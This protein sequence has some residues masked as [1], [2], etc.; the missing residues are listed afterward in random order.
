VL[1]GYEVL[2]A[3]DGIEALEC[4]HR[5]LPD[6]M[7]LDIGLPRLDGFEVARRVRASPVLAGMFIAVVTGFGT[8][9][10]RERAMRAGVHEYLVK[11][12]AADRMRAV[13]QAAEE[14]RAGRAPGSA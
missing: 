10:E 6:V 3:R 2:T 5:D 11:P 12:V 8:P 9:V 4:A 14:Q 7:L 13:L 1:Y